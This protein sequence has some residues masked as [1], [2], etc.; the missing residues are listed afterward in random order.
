M[1][2]APRNSYVMAVVSTAEWPAAASI[3]LVSRSLAA[4]GGGGIASSGRIGIVANALG[5]SLQ[6]RKLLL[7]ERHELTHGLGVKDELRSGR[8]EQLR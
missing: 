6:L 3:T 8:L 1:D 5:R 2:A 7:D 4:A